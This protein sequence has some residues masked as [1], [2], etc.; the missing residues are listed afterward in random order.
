VDFTDNAVLI[1]QGNLDFI[2]KPL[3]WQAQLSPLKDAV[4]TDVNADGLPDILIM[5]NYYDANIE[6][7]RYDADFGSVLLN[8]GHADFNVET[9]KG[10]SVKGQ[11]RHIQRIAIGADTAWLLARNSDS[12][13]LIR[14]RKQ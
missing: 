1:N 6:M 14:R 11:V 5:G 7:G 13:K 8:R 3:P 9:M 2:T 10:I 12:L 4:V